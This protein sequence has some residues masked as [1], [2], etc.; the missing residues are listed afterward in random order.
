ML[1]DASYSY[2]SRMLAHMYQNGI[3]SMSQFVDPTDAWKPK[4]CPQFC[5]RMRIDQKNKTLYCTI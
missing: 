4:C 5:G 3:G 1:L 2:P